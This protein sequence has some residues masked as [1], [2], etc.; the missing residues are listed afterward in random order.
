MMALAKKLG[1]PVAAAFPWATYEECLQKTLGRQFKKMVENGYDANKGYEPIPLAEAFR[2][3][4]KKFHFISE[5][6]RMEADGG[7]D[8]VPMSGDPARFPLTLVPYDSMRLAHGASADSPFMMKI[9]EDHVSK[10][11]DGFVE[12]NTK[13][14]GEQG[15]AEGVLAVLSTPKGEVKVRVHTSDA[16]L[17]GVIAMPRGLGHTAGSKY[18]A[19]KG[20]NVNSLIEPVSDPVSGLD[21]AWG[22]RANLVIA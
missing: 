4:D 18:V 14:A 22:I 17:P 13:T 7:P 1:E 16:I 2:T 12:V 3:P 21:A 10:G 20:A 8:R 9:V 15:L 19:F 5:K 6:C 11:T